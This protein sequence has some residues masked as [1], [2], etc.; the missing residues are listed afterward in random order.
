M[1]DSP[2]SFLH[3]QTSDCFEFGL[4]KQRIPDACRGVDIIIGIDE[5]GRGPVLGSLIYTIAFWP[6]NEH[7]QIKSSWNF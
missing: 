1:M 3:P 5:A 7:E 2:E 6:A 4:P